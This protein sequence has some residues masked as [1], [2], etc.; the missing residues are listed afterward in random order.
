MPRIK[1]NPRADFEAVRKDV[2]NMLDDILTKV[3]SEIH[4][5]VKDDDHWSPAT[6]IYETGTHL[7]MV[8]DLPGVAQ[9]EID[10]TLKE[11][12]V[13]ISGKK[14]TKED[15]TKNYHRVERAS[16]DFER[17][18]KLPVE[19]DSENINAT[20]QNGVLT[21]TFNK[22]EQKSSKKIEINIS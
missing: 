5:E 6:D 22:T 4:S 19:I 14:K 1:I 15:E 17:R 18:F 10:L 2:N 21:V 3:R 8:M 16:G 12:Y 20:F 13:I 7:V 11:E 9:E